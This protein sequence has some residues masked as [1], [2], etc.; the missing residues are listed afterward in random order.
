MEGRVPWL[1]VVTLFVLSSE[2]LGSGKRTGLALSLS[3]EWRGEMFVGYT[4]TLL[5][6]NPNLK[7]RIVKTEVADFKV[8]VVARVMM[9][10]LGS[11]G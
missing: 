9:S 6:R 7:N 5:W 2:K 1:G 11:Q 8:S 4:I 3:H 10:S